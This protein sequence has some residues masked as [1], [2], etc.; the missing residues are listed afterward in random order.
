MTALTTLKIAVVAPIPSASVITTLRVKSGAPQHPRGV[1]VHGE[2][3]VML[4][5]WDGW[6]TS[7]RTSESFRARRKLEFA[8]WGSN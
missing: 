7:E 3:R 2:H 8:Y 4:R 5:H 1:K 6:G